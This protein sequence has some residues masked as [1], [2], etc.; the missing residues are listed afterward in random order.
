[1]SVNDI[2]GAID[3]ITA[4]MDQRGIF[5]GVETKPKPDGVSFQYTGKDITGIPFA[6][7]QPEAWK[8]AVLVVSEVTINDE[9][10]KSIEAM[11]QEDR[12][13]F[14]YNLQKDITFLPAPFAYDPTHAKTGIPRGIQFSKEICYDGLTEDR[15]NDAVRDVVRSALFVIWE[16]RNELGNPKQE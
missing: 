3:L 16:I 11:R 8:R 2:P 10:V 6:I 13:E 1:M 14:L 5:D 12:D 15:L 9:R 4:W 7:I